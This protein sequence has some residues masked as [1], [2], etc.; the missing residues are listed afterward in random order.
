MPARAHDESIAIDGGRRHERLPSQSITGDDLK[1]ASWPD[2]CGKPFLVKQV[3][4]PL[5]VD[6]RRRVRALHTFLPD[7]LSGSR[8]KAGRD[9]AAVHDKQQVIYQ[10]RRTTLRHAAD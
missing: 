7:D 9:A 3:N 10:Q 8:L 4:S 6:G 2:D 5:C 1:F